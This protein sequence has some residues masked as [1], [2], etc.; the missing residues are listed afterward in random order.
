MFHYKSSPFYTT[1]PPFPHFINHFERFEFGQYNKTN[2]NPE[3][4]IWTDN[5]KATQYKASYITVF[6]VTSKYSIGVSQLQLK[7]HLVFGKLC[8]RQHFW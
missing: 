8:Y 6:D 4:V 7:E 1:N 2:T 3:K 5:N